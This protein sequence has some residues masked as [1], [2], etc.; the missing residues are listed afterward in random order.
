MMSEADKTMAEEVKQLSEVRKL[1]TGLLQNIRR[2]GVAG[3]NMMEGARLVRKG[4]AM[5]VR[6]G[7]ALSRVD[8]I[9][10]KGQGKLKRGQK[11][12]AAASPR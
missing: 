3:G 4:I 6:A 7:K 1:Q 9:T 12:V 11:M 5:M 8:G 2:L 10:K